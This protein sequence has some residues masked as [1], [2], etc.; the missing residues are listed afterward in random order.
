MTRYLIRIVVAV[1]CALF[2]YIQG[3]A[4]IR[5]ST[6]PAVNTLRRPNYNNTWICEKLQPGI[7]IHELVDALGDPIGSEGA[8]LFS[9]GATEKNI[10][11]I[12]QNGVVKELK[13]RP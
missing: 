9:G 3:Q 1:G 12:A 2:G 7:S 5:N 11:V 10:S 13:C 6:K 8:M 4:S